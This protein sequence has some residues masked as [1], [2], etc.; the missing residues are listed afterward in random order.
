MT[1]KEA[2]ELADYGAKNGVG[3]Y[4]MKNYKKMGYHDYTDYYSNAG[5]LK[6]E[7]THAIYGVPLIVTN[8]F[9]STGKQVFTLTMTFSKKSYD[10]GG[11]D[12]I[13]QIIKSFKIHGLSS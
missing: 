2:A 10:N 1:A 5:I 4:I 8:Y 12:I 7:Y 11:E 6:A 3:Q 9:I 13:N